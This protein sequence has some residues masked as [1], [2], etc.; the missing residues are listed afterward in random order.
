MS[1]DLDQLAHQVALE[2]E[3]YVAPDPSSRLGSPLPP[4]WYE[5]G[6]A[7]MRQALVSPYLLEANDHEDG[8]GGA[9]R[10]VIVVADDAQET[11]LAFDPHPDGDFVLVWRH[12]DEM[13]ISYIRRDAVGCFLSR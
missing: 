8:A 6:L 5:A 1:V 9:S 10:S 3:T 11:L 2:I 7:E 4:E 12:P 13:V